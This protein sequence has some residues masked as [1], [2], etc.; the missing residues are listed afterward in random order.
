MQG[1]LMHPEFQKCMGLHGSQ[2]MWPTLQ[3]GFNDIFHLLLTK[4]RTN[5]ISQ[6]WGHLAAGN[7]KNCGHTQYFEEKPQGRALNASLNV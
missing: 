7:Y 2:K 3:T 6:M 4:S 1:S 5:G